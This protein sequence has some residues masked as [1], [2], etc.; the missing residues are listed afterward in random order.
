M[1]GWARGLI[2]AHQ[3]TLRWTEGDEGFG[4][5]LHH[6]C[7]GDYQLA[8][9]FDMSYDGFGW[10][11]WGRAALPK[12]ASHPARRELQRLLGG[13]GWLACWVISGHRRIANNPVWIF[14]QYVDPFGH[15]ACSRMFISSELHAF[16]DKLRLKRISDRAGFR[17]KWWEPLKVKSQKRV[18]VQSVDAFRQWIWSNYINAFAKWK[19]WKG[20]SVIVRK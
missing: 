8:I 19:D 13:Q 16:G 1:C 7:P 6:F 10:K 11:R 2:F 12:D 20:E 5:R 14:N 9:V 15:C 3:R 18:M 4:Q 17:A